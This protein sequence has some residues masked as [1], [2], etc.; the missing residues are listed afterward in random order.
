[1][2]PRRE[3]QRAEADAYREALGALAALKRELAAMTQVV[4]RLEERVTRLER[5]VGHQEPGRHRAVRPPLTVIR[6]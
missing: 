1:V 2:C 4:S 5:E 6:P 3:R